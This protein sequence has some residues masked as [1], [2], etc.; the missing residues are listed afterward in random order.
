MCVCVDIYM[1]CVCHLCRFLQERGVRTKEDTDSVMN[2]EEKER[3]VRDEGAAGE[4]AGLAIE[5]FGEADG[6]QD[7][8]ERV[9][10]VCV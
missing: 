9:R 6:A 2:G 4:S 8:D 7:D 1:R 5:A 3:P 10:K